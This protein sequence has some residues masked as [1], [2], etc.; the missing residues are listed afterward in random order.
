MYQRKP[1]I[2]KI[3]YKKWIIRDDKKIFHWNK[4]VVKINRVRNYALIYVIIDII[5]DEYNYT[6]KMEKKSVLFEFICKC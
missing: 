1:N 6:I 5:I 2:L 3:N 4:V